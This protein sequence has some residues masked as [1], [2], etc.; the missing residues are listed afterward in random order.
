MSKQKSLEDK[1]KEWEAKNPGIEMPPDDFFTDAPD[2]KKEEKAQAVAQQ[3]TPPANVPAVPQKKSLPNRSQIKTWKDAMLALPVGL[4]STPL[5]ERRIQT[6]VAFAAQIIRKNDYLQQADPVTIYDAV[7][8]AARIGLTLNPALGLCY[9]VPR[10]NNKAQRVECNLEIGYRGWI[11]TLRDY[12]V[13]RDMD[14]FVVYEDETFSWNPAANMLIHEPKFAASESEHKGRAVKCAYCRVITSDGL[15]TYEVIPAWEL[16][17]IKAVSSAASKG[18][19]PHES[20]ADEMRKKGPIK[21]KAKKLLT[22]QNDERIHAMF[23]KEKEN[24]ERDQRP[25]LEAFQSAEIM[26]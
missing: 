2:D 21:R 12:G 4:S 5:D 3:A 17:K 8:Y 15:I 10:K 11:A 20:W 7:V 19:S 18:F 9:L 6:E 24:D 13:I 26:E 25:S 14:A 22:L 23:Q 1:K 16:E